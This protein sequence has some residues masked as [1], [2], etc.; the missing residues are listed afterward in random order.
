MSEAEDLALS[1]MAAGWLAEL[2]ENPALA[3]QGLELTLAEHRAGAAQSDMLAKLA[4]HWS[5]NNDAATPDPEAVWRACGSPAEPVR[6]LRDGQPVNVPRV[7]EPGAPA[8]RRLCPAHAGTLGQGRLQ[9]NPGDGSGGGCDFPVRVRAEDPYCD[10]CGAVDDLVPG[11]DGPERPEMVCADFDACLANRERR[12]P[13][14]LARVP[15]WVF[16]AQARITD[17]ESRRMIMAACEQAAREFVLELTAA[18]AREG[19]VLEL[20]GQPVSYGSYSVRG[21]W[22]PL[23][24]SY[25]INWAHI[26]WQH[27]LRNRAH[28]GHLISGNQLTPARIS[29]MAAVHAAR[30]AQVAQ[31]SPQDAGGHQPARREIPPEGLPEGVRQAIQGDHAGGDLPMVPEAQPG[32]PGA[33]QRPARVPRDRFGNR[34]YPRRRGR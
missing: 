14:D 26:N 29:A 32:Q 28:H 16:E 9:V 24:P 8:V 11:V 3:I 17:E 23:Q 27:T 21:D 34:R 19:E 2:R 1:S 33:P 12:Y 5:T 31:E 20:A 10:F 30:S 6:I 13:P 15:S 4:M 7:P 18:A 22:Y 25:N